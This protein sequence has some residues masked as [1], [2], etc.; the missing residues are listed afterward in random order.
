MTNKTII[1]D[2]AHREETRVAVLENGILQDFDREAVGVKH[3][4]GNI[5][6]AK[7]TRVEP[8]LQAAF[9][10]YGEERHGFLPFADIHPE[11][12]NL[13]EAEKQKLREL[14]SR[15]VAPHVEA[16]EETEDAST[17][18]A[19]QASRDDARIDERREERHERRSDDRGSDRRSN[20]RG[21]RRS[22]DRGGRD[23]R[24]DSRSREPRERDEDP[25]STMTT[26]SYSVEDETENHS[27][28]IHTVY[29]RYNIQDVIK[30]GQALLIQATKEERGNKGASMTTYI[31]LAGKYCVLMSNTPNKGGVS[32]KVDNFRDRKILKAILGELTIP[33]EMSVII[34]TAGVGKKPEEIKRDYEYLSRLWESINEMAKTSTAPTFIHAEDD[35]IK[36]CIRDVYNEQ[37]S[38]VVIEGQIAFDSVS[39]FI[40]ATMPYG[41]HNIKL[42]DERVPIFNKHRVE[43]QIAALYEKTIPLKSGGSI[44][45]DHTEA[46]VAIDVNSGRSTKESGVEET[47]YTTNLEAAREIARQLRLRDLAGL[48]VID[49]ID[50]YDQKHRR[51]IERTLRDELQNDRARIQLGRI[52][53]FGLMEM[54]RQRLGASLFET[55]T[56]PCKHCSGTGYIRSVE[57]LAV[58]ILRSIR[59]ACADKQVGVIYV[60]TSHE[61]ISYIANYKKHDIIAAEKNYNVHIFMHHSDD[62]G[63]GGFTIKKRKGLSDDER[64]E[65]EMEVT[66]GKVNQLGLERLFIENDSSEK[67]LG[68]EIITEDRSS[69]DRDD[70]RDNRDNRGDRNNDNR[71]GD[72]RNGGRNNQRVNNRRPRGNDNRRFDDRGDRSGSQNKGGSSSSILGSFMKI[73][74]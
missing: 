17:N 13:P 36:R 55:I 21:D 18:L 32:R 33:A 65:L 16:V 14:T 4:K 74:K 11:Y 59:H 41:E 1:I 34:R 2:A 22:D 42:H 26:G 37:V 35:V 54:S 7:I 72:R 68:E 23:R 5:Y 29:K 19:A 71:G 8:S 64:R 30:P 50:M 60:Y 61:V 12:Y 45:V 53:L 66:T 38:E 39:N 52:S 57:I 20:D 48:I 27:S 24:D 49:F 62:V 28:N 9:I 67:P 43:Q 56:E 63:N 73:F 44:V 69:R 47:A 3:I 10:D 40:K 31:S 46:L 15:E 58:G 25:E 70:R 51:N 6:L